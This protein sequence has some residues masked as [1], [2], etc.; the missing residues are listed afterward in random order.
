MSQRAPLMFVHSPMNFIYSHPYLIVIVRD[1]IH[2]YRYELS[3]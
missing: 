3:L 1:N 2:I